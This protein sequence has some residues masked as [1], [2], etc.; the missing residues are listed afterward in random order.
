MGL[1]AASMTAD[2]ILQALKE[3]FGEA[4]LQGDV[5]GGEVRVTVTPSQSVELLGFLCSLGFEYLNCLSGVDWIGQGEL[6]VV[7]NLSSL[8][9]KHKAEVNVRIPR[10][11]PVV[12]SVISIW[13]TANWHEREVYDLLGIRFEGHPD[14]RR[15]LLSEDWVGHPLRKDYEDERLVRYT[16]A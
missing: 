13:K 6:E 11:N 4:V 12:R 15:I 14:H 1:T 8:Q 10:E 7:Y 16:P 5:K 2:Q 9:Y 3:R